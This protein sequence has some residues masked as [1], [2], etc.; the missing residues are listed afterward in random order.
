M[1][2]EI[3]IPGSIL[4]PG[5]LLWVVSCHGI[6][7]KGHTGLS[8]DTSHWDKWILINWQSS[9]GSKCCRFGAGL[10]EPAAKVRC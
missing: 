2:R 10:L 5:D 8:L 4:G 1:H 3:N 9:L 7:L 6:R